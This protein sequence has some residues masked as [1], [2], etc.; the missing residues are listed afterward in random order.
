L[1][2]D[3]TKHGNLSGDVPDISY[4]PNHNYFGFDTLT[5]IASNPDQF[6]DTGIIFIT[7]NPINDRPLTFNLIAPEDSS[8]YT[9]LQNGPADSLFFQYHR[10]IDVDHDSLY[11]HYRLGQQSHTLKGLTRDTTINKDRM[12]STLNLV[13][14][15]E[16]VP[17]TFIS[18][19]NQKL[20][21]ILQ[22]CAISRGEFVWNIWVKD[23]QNP[24]RSYEEG[25]TFCKISLSITLS[26][27]KSMI[28]LIFKFIFFISSVQTLNFY[29]F[30]ASHSLHFSHLL[31]SIGIFLLRFSF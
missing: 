10:S 21:E 26:I 20:I 23:E 28:F 16:I 5:F 24:V 2:G 17:D 30:W 4:T 11:Y 29:R 18:I 8:L 14:I 31:S 27:V 25:W 13:L 1:I 19:P 9:I 6:S 7:I 15:D 22:Q 12:E 3:S